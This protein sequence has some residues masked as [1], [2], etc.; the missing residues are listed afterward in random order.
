MISGHI[1]A[2][3][4]VQ[5][6][7]EVVNPDDTFPVVVGSGAVEDAATEVRVLVPPLWRRR[8][9]HVADVARGVGQHNVLGN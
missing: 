3:G 6:D 7:W 5:H 4:W 9:E 8:E 1:V 2:L